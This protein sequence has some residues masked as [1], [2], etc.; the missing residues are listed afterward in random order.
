VREVGDLHLLA[1]LRSQNRHLG[2]GPG[3]I[4]L[5]QDEVNLGRQRGQHLR[6]GWLAWKT[7]TDLQQPRRGQG[8]SVGPGPAVA[9]GVLALIFPVQVLVMAVL[10]HG[11]PEAPGRK[12]GEQ[13]ADEFGLAGVGKSYKGNGLGGGWSLAGLGGAGLRRGGHSETGTFSSIFS[14]FTSR[15]R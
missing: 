10:E 8:H 7:V 9:P 2:K 1:G 15:L 12:S 14:R 13:A 4:A 11:D 6:E 3:F 5:H